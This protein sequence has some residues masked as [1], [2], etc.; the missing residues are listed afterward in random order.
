MV[1]EHPRVSFGLSVAL[2]H[3][4]QQREQGDNIDDYEILRTVLVQAV[5]LYLLGA[6]LREIR[7]IEADGI[8]HVLDRDHEGHRLVG[9]P[10]H[11]EAHLA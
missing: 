6:P 3:P 2:G 1:K 10:A 5:L 8:A 7:G 11:E 9:H 4:E